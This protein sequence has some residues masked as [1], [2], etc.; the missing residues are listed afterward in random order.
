MIRPRDHNVACAVGSKNDEIEY[1]TKGYYSLTTSTNEELSSKRGNYIKKTAPCRR[2][3]AILEKSPLSG[4]QID[5]LTIDAEGNDFDVLNSLNL[6]TYKPIVVAIETNE[7]FLTEVIET[8]EFKLLKNSG[9]DL[10]AWCGMTM[11]FFNK[12][13]SKGKNFDLKIN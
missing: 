13:F 9:Y 6:E 10:V 12:E 1:Y 5:F 3:D 8:N 4:Q 11:I 2:L 7:S